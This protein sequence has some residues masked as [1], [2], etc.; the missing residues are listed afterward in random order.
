VSRLV[1]NHLCAWE[2]V[3]RMK[4]SEIR[5]RHGNPDF[6]PAYNTPGLHPGY[7]LCRS[8]YLGARGQ[9]VSGITGPVP[10]P[11]QRRASTRQA[12]RVASSGQNG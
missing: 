11:S 10:M 8:S 12:W 5:V 1:R 2:P 6:G 7:M 9:R 4:R 3:A